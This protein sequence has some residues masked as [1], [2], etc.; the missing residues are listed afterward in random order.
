MPLLPEIRIL[1][2]FFDNRSKRIEATS[3]VFLIAKI[4]LTNLR[5]ITDKA[6]DT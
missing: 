1:F 6:R 5:C 4:E 2:D 3:S